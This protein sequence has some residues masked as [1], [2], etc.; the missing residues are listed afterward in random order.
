MHRGLIQI[1]CG[2]GKG[3]T[4]AAVGL[5][6]RAA[7]CGMQILFAQFLKSNNT[8]ERSVFSSLENVIMPEIPPD[9]K[10][11]KD[12]SEVEFAHAKDFFSSLFKQCY[13][14]AVSGDF[15]IVVMDEIFSAI[16]YGIVTNEILAELLVQKSPHTELVLTGRD[17]HESIIKLADYVTEMQLIKHPYRRGISARK[18]IE[19]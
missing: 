13:D 9:T 4:T 11:V 3:K 10:F 6:T 14:C 12:M 18:G 5:C 15:D 1:Y 2:D 7:G 17:P 8:G 16:K 19:F